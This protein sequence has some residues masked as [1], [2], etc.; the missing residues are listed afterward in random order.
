MKVK[1]VVVMDRYGD[2]SRAKSSCV[3][4]VVETG[5]MLIKAYEEQFIKPEI[6]VVECGYGLALCHYLKDKG[7]PF[8]IREVVLNRI[9]GADVYK[10]R[11][12]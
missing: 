2:E 4:T 10:G 8:I 3:H 7:I 5:D 1:W 12:G 6:E 9:G 11:K